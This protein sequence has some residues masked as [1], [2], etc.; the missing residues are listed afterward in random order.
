MKLFLV[1]NV[2]CLHLEQSNNIMYCN[3]RPRPQQYSTIA[4]G[5]EIGVKVQRAEISVGALLSYQF[6]CI[7][8]QSEMSPCC[9]CY[10]RLG[11]A[12]GRIC[13]PP[14][15]QRLQRR[16]SSKRMITDCRYPNS[17]SPHVQFSLM[18]LRKSSY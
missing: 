11:L 8:K 1:K 4:H 10:C 13:L 18:T 9:I 2:K 15:T 6:F 3:C 14:K 12:I 5:C 17:L 16:W 7:R